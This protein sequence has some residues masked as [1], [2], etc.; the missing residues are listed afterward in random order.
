MSNR[1]RRKRNKKELLFVLLALVALVFSV[2]FLSAQFQSETT[3]T[4][5]FVGPQGQRSSNFRVEL[6]M[7]P[8]AR[9]KGL[10]FRKEGDLAANEGM[11]FI[12]PIQKIQSFWMK[13]TYINLDMIFIDRNKNVVGVLHDVPS[14]T[15]DLRSVGE[16][17]LYVLELLGGEARKAGIERGWTMQTRSDLPLVVQ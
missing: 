3:N 13:N 16:P 1:S 2:S 12:F 7:T 9:E 4:V 5:Y 10:M 6:A 15:T 8:G 17:S 11:L 14:G